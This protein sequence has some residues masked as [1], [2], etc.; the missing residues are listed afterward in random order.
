MKPFRTI[1]ALTVLAAAAFV[2]VP[3]QPADAGTYMNWRM[4]DAQTVCVTDHGRTN[5]PLV[6]A[7]RAWDASRAVGVSVTPDCSA[8]PRSQVVEVVTYSNPKENACAKTGSAS[9]YDWVYTY[10][11]DGTRTVS[12]VPRDMTIWINVA[13]DLRAGCYAT[14]TMRLHVTAHEIGHALGLGH[15]D[16]AVQSVLSGW[17][18]STPTA[19]DLANIDTLYGVPVSRYLRRPT[20]PLR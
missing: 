20:I 10:K 7:A 13:L 1:A 2:A 8:F 4:R 5:L 19:W 14:P 3:P 18:Y 9:G 6:E 17:T 12:W 15:P 11:P 16:G